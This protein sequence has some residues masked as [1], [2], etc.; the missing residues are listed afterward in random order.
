MEQ[1]PEIEEDI[2]YIVHGAHP[3]SSRYF[4]EHPV[5]TLHT[6][7][8]GT[9]R[10]LALAR[11]KQVRSFVF[12]STMEVYG[13]PRRGSRITEE[14]CGQFDPAVVRSCYPLGKLLGE[15]LCCSYCSEYGVPVKIARLTQTFGPGVGYEDG[16]VF[17]EFARC[18]IERRNIV[19]K[20]RGE[21]ERAYL[22]T[23]DAVWAILAILLKGEN[24][25]AYTAANEETYCSIHEMASMVAGKYGIQVEIRE[26]D[27]A[28]QGYAD[29]L[30]MDLDTSKLQKLGWRPETGLEEM[31][32]RMIRSM[33][34]EMV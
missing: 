18:A 31:Y 1:L 12:L 3:T 29:T 22:Y 25:Q 24:G 19:L 8:Y 15:S 4:I 6:A 20:T 17:A 10:L 13:R 28:S 2:D 26:Q 16:R 33:K 7:V 9:D 32:D 14:C 34:K 11:E 23:E 27:T 30:Y 21:T 5:E